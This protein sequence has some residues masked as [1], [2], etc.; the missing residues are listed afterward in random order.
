MNYVSL[1]IPNIYPFYSST[2]PRNHPVHLLFYL[3]ICG[4]VNLNVSLRKAPSSSDSTLSGIVIVTPTQQYMHEIRMS[5]LG[6]SKFTIAPAGGKEIPD[7]ID[8]DDI[9]A[10]N[11]LPCYYFN[12]TSMFDY[13]IL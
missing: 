4:T 10:G 11:Y 9:F 7:F 1:I 5:G 13:G 2:I 6:N 3:Q 12:S 8:L